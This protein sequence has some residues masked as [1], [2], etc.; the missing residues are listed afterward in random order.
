VLKGRLTERKRPSLKTGVPSEGGVSL[1]I[2]RLA[3]YFGLETRAIN[4]RGDVLLRILQERKDGASIEGGDVLREP[5]LGT[6]NP[7]EAGNC[8]GGVVQKEIG[9]GGNTTS[10]GRSRLTGLGTEEKG[11]DRS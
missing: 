9:R 2:K 4:T 6:P 7:K 1:R 5:T 10:R 3:R 8:C 11:E